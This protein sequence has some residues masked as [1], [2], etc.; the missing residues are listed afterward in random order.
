[1]SIEAIFCLAVG[2]G[3]IIGMGFAKDWSIRVRVPLVLG[4]VGGLL[5]L[6]VQ[7]EKSL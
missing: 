4:A 7:L 5:W 6:F 3:A 2:L 1:M